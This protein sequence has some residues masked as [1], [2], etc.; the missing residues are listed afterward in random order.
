MDRFVED[1]HQNQPEPYLN[2]YLV[3]F[4]NISTPEELIHEVESKKGC[5]DL[6]SETR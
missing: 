2:S 3:A 4:E 1:L 6:L 5:C